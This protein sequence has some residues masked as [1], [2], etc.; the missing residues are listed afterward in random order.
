[1]NTVG[2]VA[3]PPVAKDSAGWGWSRFFW[4]SVVS[5]TFTVWACN[6][7]MDANNGHLR[8]HGSA[9]FVIYGHLRTHEKFAASSVL[10]DPEYF[11]IVGYGHS[12]RVRTTPL[13]GFPSA[14]YLVAIIFAGAE[15]F[16]THCSIAFIML[17]SGSAAAGD[18]APKSFGPGPPPQCCMPGTMNSSTN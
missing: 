12:G 6:S 10:P 14:L 11:E 15:P 5:H 16:S 17:W 13:A 7:P 18:M 8:L 4:S 9:F 3:D 1:M 2:I